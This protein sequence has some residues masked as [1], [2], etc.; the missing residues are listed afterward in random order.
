MN[1]EERRM[2]TFEA[3]T[4]MMLRKAERAGREVA[5]FERGEVANMSEEREKP[6]QTVLEAVLGRVGGIV[7]E[8]VVEAIAG[9]HP[10]LMDEPA[11][12]R[13]TEA[14]GEACME[15]IWGP[16]LEDIKHLV[17]IAAKAGRKD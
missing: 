7:E 6:R 11:I 10:E 5:K 16:L 9:Y 14:I 15:V 8:A 12:S 13:L 3:E 2:R 17:H 1:E 4:E